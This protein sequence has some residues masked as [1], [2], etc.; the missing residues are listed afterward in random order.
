MLST[1][2]GLR[3]QGGRESNLCPPLNCVSWNCIVRWLPTDEEFCFRPPSKLLS[4][5]HTV[6]GTSSHPTTY[7]AERLQIQVRVG[8]CSGLKF[9]I[10]HQ[11]YNE[12][13]LFSK[14]YFISP[15]SLLPGP[16]CWT[17][18]G[19][20]TLLSVST[21]ANTGTWLVT[22]FFKNCNTTLASQVAVCQGKAGRQLETPLRIVLTK[23]CV[24]TDVLSWRESVATALHAWFKQLKHTHSAHMKQLG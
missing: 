19:T 21:G 18:T 13:L 1:A 14:S 11:T 6:S 16:F 23:G 7:L 2:N 9:W 12:R 10:G 5:W 3:V 8:A 15:S 4:Y 20:I 22:I 24:P 17:P